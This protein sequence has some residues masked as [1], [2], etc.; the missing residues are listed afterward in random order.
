MKCVYID[1][2]KEYKLKSATFQYFVENV[3]GLQP[4][5]L[6]VT[7]PWCGHCVQFKPEIKKT[8]DGIKASNV[9]YKGKEPC[10]YILHL[11]DETM[12]HIVSHHR[13]SLLGQVVAQNVNGF[14]T[15]LLAS[16][17]NKSNKMNILHFE[18]ERTSQNLHKFVERAVR[19]SSHKK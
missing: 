18:G 19:L 14:P 4:F 1:A 3:L 7:A 11:S 5:I 16:T 9:P 6:I 2:Q 13:Q 8:L 15:C 17:I 10:V 12:Q